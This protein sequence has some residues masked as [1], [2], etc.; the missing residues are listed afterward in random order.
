MQTSVVIPICGTSNSWKVAEP[1]DPQSLTRDRLVSLEIQGDVTNGYHLNMSPD[2]C[3]TAD[4][5]H[6]TIEDALESAQRVFGVPPASWSKSPR[7]S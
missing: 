4:S 3:F 5:W 7:R 2:G 6:A 1:S